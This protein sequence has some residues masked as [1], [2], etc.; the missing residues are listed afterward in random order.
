MSDSPPTPAAWPQLAGRIEERE[1]VLPLRVYFEDTDF[2]GYVFH[3]SYLRWCERGRSDWLRLLGVS[4]AELYKG[5]NGSPPLIFIV[6]NMDMSFKAPAK[7]DEVLEV[8]TSTKEW[9][10]ASI[11]LKQEI[12][13]DGR[14]LMRAIVQ[15]VLISDTGKPQRL[16]KHLV[17][18]FGYEKPGSG[19]IIR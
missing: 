13:R 11:T 9:S 5:Y 2:T 14:L 17:D 8:R 4:H 16:P 18:L 19:V 7:I 6:R 10:G 3:G 15:V 12:R 1:H